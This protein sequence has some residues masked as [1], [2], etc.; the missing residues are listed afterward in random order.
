MLLYCSGFE[1]LL[2]TKLLEDKAQELWKLKFAAWKGMTKKKK[3]QWENGALMEVRLLF[4]I[5]KL[6]CLYEFL[7]IVHVYLE[8][9]FCLMA[10]VPISTT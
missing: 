4:G 3:E 10:V 2:L 9:N 6:L 5:L 8:M 7:Y 1:K